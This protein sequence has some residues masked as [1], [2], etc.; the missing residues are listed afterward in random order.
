MNEDDKA[1]HVS[2]TGENWEVED[3]SQ[4]LAQAETKEEAISAAHEAASEVGADKVVV[5]TSDGHVVQE[6][7]VV[8]KSPDGED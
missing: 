8:K 4:T 5:H 3:E 1:V 6:I 7:P 2:P